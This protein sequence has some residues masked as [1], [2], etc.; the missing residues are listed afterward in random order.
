M[1]ELRCWLTRFA[2]SENAKRP[3]WN[4]HET[5]LIEQRN[6]DFAAA[7]SVKSQPIIHL[8]NG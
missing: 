6:Y 5:V 3:A 8:K 4:D 7:D 1:I 2:A